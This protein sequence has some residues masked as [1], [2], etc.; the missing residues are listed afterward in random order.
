MMRT[1]RAELSTYTCGFSYL[2]GGMIG[3]LTGFLCSDKALSHLLVLFSGWHTFDAFGTC[4]AA[5]LLIA[6]FALLLSLSA[7]GSVLIPILVLAAGYYSGI[8]LFSAA[9]S[10]AAVPWRLYPLFLFFPDILVLL[11]ITSHGCGISLQISRSWTSG[12]I[13]TF[14]LNN[15]LYW[16]WIE[17]IILWI[18]YAIR[19]LFF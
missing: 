3:C 19:R 9:F 4:F 15:R 11:R 16:I 1:K 5:E 7:Y 6:V 2:L 18:L 14:D 12:G 10:E 8:L 17:L 13:R